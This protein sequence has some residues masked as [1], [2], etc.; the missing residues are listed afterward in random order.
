M[1]K[2]RR[3]TF[4]AL[5][6]GAL[7]VGGLAADLHWHEQVARATTHAGFISP[8]DRAAPPASAP[9]S[10]LWDKSEKGIKLR[11]PADW[12][13]KKNPDYELMLLPPGA[14]KEDRRITVDIPDLPPHLPFMIQIGR[15]EHDYVQD[16]KKEHPDLKVQESTG[17]NVPES[18]SKLVRSIWRQNGTTYHDAALLVVH[19]S[20]VYIVDAETEEAQLPAT[21]SAFDSI[22]GSI[23]W[24]KH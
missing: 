20:A 10:V 5:V 16:L 15:V 7:C 3:R 6:V 21:T 2:R 12:R 24:T 9:A 14:S 23:Q 17:G 13:P 19:A 22:R 11:Y 4:A 8:G 18:T 1:S